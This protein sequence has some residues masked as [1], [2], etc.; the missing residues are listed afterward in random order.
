[1]VGTL[2]A[3]HTDSDLASGP[4][5]KT[6]GLDSGSAHTTRTLSQFDVTI[7]SQ[8]D[9][10]ELLELGTDDWYPVDINRNVRA[11]G[12]IG[13]LFLVHVPDEGETYDAWHI[14][15]MDLVNLLNQEMRSMLLAMGPYGVREVNASDRRAQVWKETV[16]ENPG[17]T[18]LC[19]PNTDEQ[20]REFFNI[21][22]AN[23]TK[24]EKGPIS[25]TFDISTRT[26]HTDKK[27]S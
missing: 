6:D 8:S 14:A 7:D 5:N 2:P 12:I 3:Q 18:Y 20:A 15:G 17:T 10:I 21:D 26:F 13:C 27:T 11:I 4:A 16:Q 23:V 22:T 25:V 1:M 9:D 19:G 24:T